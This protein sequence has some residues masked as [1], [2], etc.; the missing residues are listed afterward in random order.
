MFVQH[1]A[2]KVQTGQLSEKLEWH[3]ES[4]FVRDFPPPVEV[5]ATHGPSLPRRAFKCREDREP[6]ASMTRGRSQIQQVAPQLVARLGEFAW[7]CLQVLARCLEAL[8]EFFQGL[9]P[10]RPAIAILRV[11][12]RNPPL[13]SPQAAPHPSHVLQADHLEHLDVGPRV[14]LGDERRATQFGGFGNKGARRDA[15]HTGA[16]LAV[17]ACKPRAEQLFELPAQHRGTG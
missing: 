14:Q 12:Q 7:D 10:P 8:I 6:F 9:R 1:R 11:H 3:V 17:H 13:G 4:A 16:V 2:T 15:V 5:R